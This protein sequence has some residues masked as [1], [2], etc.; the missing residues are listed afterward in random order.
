MRA[1]ILILLT[2]MPAFAG[3]KC[4]DRCQGRG[5][6][7]LGRCQDGNARCFERCARDTNACWF[8]CGT[9]GTS[10]TC[11]DAKGRDRECDPGRIR[12]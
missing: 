9:L 8:G 11:R 2:A 6:S 5:A 1:L 4:V 10:V 3:D 7:C 12:E